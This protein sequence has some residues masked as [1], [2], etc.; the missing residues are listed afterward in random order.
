MTGTP[1]P[2]FN[3]DVAAVFRNKY[4]NSQVFPDHNAGGHGYRKLL[5]N[6]FGHCTTWSQAVV[7]SYFGL[8]VEAE[9]DETVDS[10]EVEYEDIEEIRQT[11]RK[12]IG[13]KPEFGD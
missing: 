2:R 13:E 5:N 1:L 4:R 9:D 12:Q 11:N 3:R 7:L 8:P 6:H 10:Q